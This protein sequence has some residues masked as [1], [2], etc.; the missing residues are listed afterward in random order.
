MTRDQIADPAPEMVR[1]GL[2]RVIH[3][4]TPSDGE[5][6]LWWTTTL[7]A[8]DDLHRWQVQATYDVFTRNGV[9]PRPED[10]TNP[11]QL[12]HIAS[13]ILPDAAFD[14]SNSRTR[15]RTCNRLMMLQ[16]AERI[17]PRPAH[18]SK[19]VELPLEHG[20]P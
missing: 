9:Q 14:T 12:C 6:A 17:P 7:P 8:P 20:T 2:R 3:P 1:N 5:R 4:H 16:R 15:S 10:L 11:N 13:M 18:R 19:V